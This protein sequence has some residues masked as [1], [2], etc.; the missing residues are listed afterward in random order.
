MLVL[1]ELICIFDLSLLLA[2]CLPTLI[3]YRCSPNFPVRDFLEQFFLKLLGHSKKKSIPSQV[4]N[5]DCVRGTSESASVGF[6]WSLW[7]SS[8]MALLYYFSVSLYQCCPYPA[9]KGSA[10]AI[11]LVVKLLEL[12]LRC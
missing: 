3:D 4:F 8:H 11:E 7:L 6:R 1:F 9:S 12:K 10:I 5:I 2:Y